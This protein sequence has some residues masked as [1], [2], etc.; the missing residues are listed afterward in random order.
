MI[1]GDATAGADYVDLHMSTSSF[2]HDHIRHQQQQL[3]GVPAETHLPVIMLCSLGILG[4][5]TAINMSALV[6]AICLLRQQALGCL[7]G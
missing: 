3:I 4:R 7:G 5:A 1:S 6:A 2:K